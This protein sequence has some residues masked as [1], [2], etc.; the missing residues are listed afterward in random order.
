MELSS[1]IAI[2]LITA[3]LVLF[4]KDY[5]PEYAILA[6]IAA[7]CVILGMVLIQVVPAIGEL[8]SLLKEANVNTSYFAVAFKALGI[9]YLTQFASDICRDFGQSS[10]AGKVDLAGKVMIVT[11]SLPLL[12]GIIEAALGLVG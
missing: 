1:I 8:N 10:L 7:G 11:I 2:A 3:M 4:L 5:R 12:K 9:C 6:A